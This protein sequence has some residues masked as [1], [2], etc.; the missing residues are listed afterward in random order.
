[1]ARTSWIILLT[2]AFFLVTGCATT[3]DPDEIP[4]VSSPINQQATDQQSKLDAAAH[5]F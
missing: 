1:M 2:T 5:T 3:T 4:T